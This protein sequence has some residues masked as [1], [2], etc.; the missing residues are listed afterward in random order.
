[1]EYFYL[2]K[3]VPAS[4]YH[5][6]MMDGKNEPLTSNVR[7]N[8]HKRQRHYKEALSK[9]LNFQSVKN[10]FRGQLKEKLRKIGTPWSARLQSDKLSF[11]DLLSARIKKKQVATYK[12]PVLF[13]LT[14]RNI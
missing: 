4:F 6:K 10:I 1:M 3:I 14:N 9:F 8:C 5:N 2:G 11:D 13:I 12:R 7:I